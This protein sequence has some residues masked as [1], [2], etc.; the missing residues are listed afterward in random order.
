MSE[1]GTEDKTWLDVL[2]TSD[3]PTSADRDRIRALV[4]TSVAT[5]GGAVIASSTVGKAASLFGI[6]WKVVLAAVSVGA[7][8][9][10]GIWVV[11]G[12]SL[13]TVGASAART[14]LETTAAESPSAAAA[15]ATT[16]PPPDDDMDVPGGY[17]VQAE[18]TARPSRALAKIPYDDIEAELGLLSRAQRAL[19]AHDSMLALQ[20]LGEHRAKFPRGSLHVER[21]GLYAVAACEAKRPEGTKLASRF[22]QNFPASPLGAR[23]RAACLSR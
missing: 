20:L 18:P 7:L 4:L 9:G 13:P 6:G 17:G 5:T 19:S 2:R 8:V 16:A 21:E 22:L 3:E 12:T 23:V 1:L 11:S 10:S 15:E 14:K